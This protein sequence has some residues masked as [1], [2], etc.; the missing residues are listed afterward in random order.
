MIECEVCHETSGDIDEC[1]HCGRI[2]CSGCAYWECV[3]DE[4]VCGN[5]YT[6]L[7]AIAEWE[8]ENGEEEV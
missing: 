6:D 3:D 5:C 1:P 7:E 4:T 2:L 8:Y